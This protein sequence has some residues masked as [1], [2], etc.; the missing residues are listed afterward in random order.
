M[1]AEQIERR[2]EIR[3]KTEGRT[4]LIQKQISRRFVSLSPLLETQT[5]QFRF[6]YA[7][8]IRGKHL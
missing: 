1:L 5:P 3:G 2:G 8:Q 4:L 6:G 7:G